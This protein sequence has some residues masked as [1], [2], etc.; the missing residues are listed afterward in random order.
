MRAIEAL[1]LLRQA[2]AP[3]MSTS[4]AAMLLGMKSSH[5]S[6]VLERLAE[7]R[8]VVRLKRAVWG[9]PDMLDPLQ[10]PE[11][12][13]APQASYIS[14]QSAMFFHG[15][16]SQIPNVVY[17][18]SP[19]RTRRWETPL[20]TVSIHHLD[21]TFFFGFE[22][23]QSGKFKMATPEKALLDCLYLMPAKSRLFASLP[24]LELEG[25]FD[26]RRAELLLEEIGSVSLRNKLRARMEILLQNMRGL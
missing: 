25:I 20:A 13:A 15:M 18:V 16:V 26:V 6:R 23:V 12:L 22:L 19:A 7:A 9:F 21:P 10:L 3:A 17:A 8:Q 2:G 11:L 1:T 5:A 4:D 24:E 14:L